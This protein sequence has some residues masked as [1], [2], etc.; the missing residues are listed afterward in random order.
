MV[1]IDSVSNQENLDFYSRRRFRVTLDRVKKLTNLKTRRCGR[2]FGRNRIVDD[3]NLISLRF[4]TVSGGKMLFLCSE[5]IQD[6]SQLRILLTKGKTR[7]RKVFPK[8][9]KRAI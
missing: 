9:R 2:K 5:G 1:A 7:K 6:G 8:K 4:L 3:G